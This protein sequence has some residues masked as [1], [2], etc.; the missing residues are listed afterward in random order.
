MKIRHDP[1]SWTAENLGN[2]M[3]VLDDRGKVIVRLYITEKGEQ[4][5]GL[6]RMIA[7]APDLLEAL[8]Y[9]LEDCCEKCVSKDFRLYLGDYGKCE[10]EAKGRK[11]VDKAKGGDGKL[12]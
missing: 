3:V 10:A 11:A 4:V 8:E 12:L 6:A 9:M 1:G 2:T 5:E 7:S